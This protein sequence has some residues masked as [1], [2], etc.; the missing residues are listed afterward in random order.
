MKK[1]LWIFNIVLL[2]ILALIAVAL[3][4][5]LLVNIPAIS[6]IA[7]FPALQ[8]AHYFLP[9]CLVLLIISALFLFGHNKAM[10]VILIILFAAA[11]GLGGFAFGKAY[12]FCKDQGAEIKV[13]GAFQPKDFSALKKDTITY[14][15]SPKGDVQLDV[16]TT[17]DGRTGKPVVVY[18]HGGGWTSGSRNNLSYRT[19]TFAQDGY[20]SITVDY[21]LSDESNHLSATTELQLTYALAWVGQH[22]TEYGGDPAHIFLIGDSAGGNLALDLAYKINGGV[23]LTAGE[24]PLP[25]IEA[26]CAL[27]PV[28][29]PAALYGSDDI[30]FG[31]GVKTV[32]EAYVG[33]S[34][35]DNPAAYAEIT[36]A[37]YLTPAA[38]RTL[39]IVGANDKLVDPQQSRDLLKALEANGT[40][41]KLIE[42][43][44][45][46]HA[47]DYIDATFACDG[48]T[49]MA[50]KF[51]RG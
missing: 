15:T 34:P 20:V 8:Y 4:V 39:L 6:S 9:A 47:F 40:Q 26:V 21:D 7:A 23:Y 3:T 35:T 16:Y 1:A 38:P 19:K 11:L 42:V 25:H 17:A 18:I 33:A 31:K 12:K 45:V 27:Y 37:N 51:F 43:P 28:A 36:P 10:P 2:T 13:W 24:T 44:Y 29:D 48:V 46:N 30:V 50:E 22:A 41:A 32:L 49:A 5:S 14:T